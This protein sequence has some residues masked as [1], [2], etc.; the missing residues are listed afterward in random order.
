ML[1]W[2]MVVLF[3]GVVVLFWRVWLCYFGVWLCYLEGMAVLFWGMVALFGGY[4]CVI[5]GYGCVI[6]GGIYLRHKKENQ[7]KQTKIR[8]NKGIT[9]IHTRPKQGHVTINTELQSI[10]LSVNLIA[11]EDKHVRIRRQM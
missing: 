9:K 1:F 4:G 10:A 11:C 3:W 8:A 5:L 6:L 2:G 7:I